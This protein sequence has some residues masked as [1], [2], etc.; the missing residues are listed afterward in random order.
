MTAGLPGLGKHPRLYR[1][2][3]DKT[4]SMS[5]VLL[6]LILIMYR[7]RSLCG[8]AEEE[9][10]ILSLRTDLFDLDFERALDI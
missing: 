3:L 8:L 7:P 10:G 1:N 2:G 9:E 5:D 6:L 4:K